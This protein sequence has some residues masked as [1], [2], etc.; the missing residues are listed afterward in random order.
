MRQATAYGRVSDRNS[1]MPASTFALHTNGCSV[2]AKLRTIKGSTCEKCYAVKFEQMYPSVHQGHMFNQ[3]AAAEHIASDPEAWAQAI[4]MQVTKICAKFNEP[5]HR[6]FDSGD[7]QDLAMLRA[8]ARVCELTPTIKHWLPTREGAILK[9]FLRER[10]LP[11]NL[12]VR[13]SATMIDDQPMKAH[14]HT[15]TVH[16]KDK[17]HAGQPCEANTRGHACGPCRACWDPTVP[18]VSYPLH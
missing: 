10:D 13:L 8:I 14:P 2:G 5:Y 1:K 4:A 16:R 9:A 11:T 17:P 18:N 15:S 6:W 3:T 12:V 7:L